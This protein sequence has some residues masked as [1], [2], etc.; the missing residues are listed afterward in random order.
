MTKKQQEKIKQEIEKKFLKI[1]GWR[2]WEEYDEIGQSSEL[3]KNIRKELINI[4]I[5]VC[6]EEFEKLIDKFFKYRGYNKL[7]E[8]LKQKLKE[9][10]R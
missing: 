2:N 5:A 9:N 4:C 1:R 8:E 7:K 3:D 6:N 10:D